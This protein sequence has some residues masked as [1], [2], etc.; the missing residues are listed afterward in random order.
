MISLLKGIPQFSGNEL[1]V[2]CGQV[3][4]GV[5][6]NEIFGSTLRQNPVETTLYIHTH[7]RED[8][9]ELFGFS[10]PEQKKLFSLF[11]SVPGVGPKTALALTNDSPERIRTAVQQGEVSFFSTFPRVGKKLAQNIII[12]LKPKLGSIVELDLAEPTGKTAELKQAL[13]SLGYAEPD[14]AK[15]LRS[16]DTEKGSIQDAIKAAIKFLQSKG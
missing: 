15:A 8:A 13:E 7:V 2:L 5:Q 9:L 16:V 10:S 3:G 12:E 11:L 4:Y 6:V 1:T 14:I